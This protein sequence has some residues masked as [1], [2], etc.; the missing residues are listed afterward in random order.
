M[1]GFAVNVQLL[2][3]YP[4]ALFGYNPHSRIKADGGWQES[5][6]L[7]NFSPGKDDTRIECKGSQKQVVS[8][9]LHSYALCACAN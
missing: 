5:R 4:N 3:Q 6:F 7:E 9:M 2:I 8:P 1:A